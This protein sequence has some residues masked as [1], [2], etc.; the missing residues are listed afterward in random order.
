MG[1]WKRLIGKVERVEKG[2]IDEGWR[3]LLIKASRL[4]NIS[5]GVMA[6]L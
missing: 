4:N 3:R 1:R 2:W 6:T 5:L